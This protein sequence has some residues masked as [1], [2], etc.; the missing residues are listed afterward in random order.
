[1]RWSEWG[2]HC[3]IALNYCWP[4]ENTSEG[5]SPALGDPGSS[6]HDDVDSWMLG[7]EDWDRWGS[8]VLESG[9]AQDFIMLLRTMCSL[10]LMNYS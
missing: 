7:A 4:S 2:R 10:K 9:T 6:S 1:M 5:G 3:D 8:R